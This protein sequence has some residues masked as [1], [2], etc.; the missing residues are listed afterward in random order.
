VADDDPLAGYDPKKYGIAPIAPAAGLPSAAAPGA[1]DPLA[2][3]DPSKYGLGPA[4]GQD[5]G[6][7]AF[8]NKPA[9]ASWSDYLLAHL[10]K[11]GQGFDQ[12]GADYGRT[13][14]DAATFGLG[15]RA[16]AYATGAP[17]EQERA[18]TAAAQSRLGVMQYP[19]EALGYAAL[20]GALVDAAGLRG[21]G[22]VSGALSGALEGTAAGTAGALGHDENPYL[23]AA[24]GAAGGALGGVVGGGLSSLSGY[25]PKGGPASPGAV[26]NTLRGVKDDAYDALKN[27]TY[28]PADLRTGL[29]GIGGSLKAVDPA[30]EFA[31]APRSKAALDG[32]WDQATDPS[33]PV[34]TA[35]SVLSTIDRL[36]DAMGPNGGAENDFAPVIKTGLN[37]F[38]QNATPTSGHA[39]G[40]AT[41]MI[42]D[43]QA[44]QKAYG[45]ARDLQGMAQNMKLWGTS[46]AGQAQKIGQT[47]YND[48]SIPANVA[49][50]Q[51][52]S[53]IAQAAGGSAIGPYQVTRMIEPALGYAGAAAGG[54]PG[55]LA[56]ELGGH[57][58]KA[59]IS[60]VMNAAQKTGTM[61][62][63]N[64]AYP[65]LTGQPGAFVRSPSPISPLMA[66][67]L[68]PGAAGQYP[69]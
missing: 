16:L 39:V 8:W 55:A 42:S 17:L 44:A 63:I 32:L 29:T 62:A 40:S 2:G 35:H 12:A 65:T 69:R 7:T 54:G 38:L 13:I 25:V 59:P 31:G 53:R 66:L 34:Q 27:V 21:A 56:A 57:L 15:D 5:L 41:G 23:G 51:A 6:S 45:N 18:N 1:T 47:F 60:G 24:G 58:L 10:A 46:P 20:P 3:Y 11:Q 61:G 30:G 50:T 26:T 43:A 67:L 68:G 37:N 48:Q 19:A 64:A 4:T 36:N 52:L 28:D 49:P 9:N 22:W 14:A 33:N